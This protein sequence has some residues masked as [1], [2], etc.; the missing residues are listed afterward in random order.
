MGLTHPL[1]PNQH[2]PLQVIQPGSA[3][4]VRA[5]R[6]TKGSLPEHPAGGTASSPKFASLRAGLAVGMHPKIKAR[7]SFLLCFKVLCSCSRNPR[8]PGQH[9]SKSHQ[10]GS[11]W[12]V[13]LGPS[14][15]HYWSSEKRI[16]LPL[17][18]ACETQNSDCCLGWQK[19]QSLL[20]NWP[21]KPFCNGPKLIHTPHG[22]IYKGA[23]GTFV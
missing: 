17:Y 23:E 16:Q 5:Q 13:P 4:D 9:C 3:P 11:D 1:Q 20:P 10:S 12:M 15:G 18:P 21:T 7:L 14:A 19:P 22:T 8:E 6:S 2:Q